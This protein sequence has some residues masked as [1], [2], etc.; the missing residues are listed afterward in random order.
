MKSRWSI[1]RKRIAAALLSRVG[2]RSPAPS[3]HRHAET[4]NLTA[5]EI[6]AQVMRRAT[7]SRTGRPTSTQPDAALGGRYITNVVLM[8]MG[9]P[10]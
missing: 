5:N 4:R 6:V 9:E 8:G 7:A 2:T 3:A 1:S 10:L